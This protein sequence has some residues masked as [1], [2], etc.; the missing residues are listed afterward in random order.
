M[1]TYAGHARP[2]RY[3]HSLSPVSGRKCDAGQGAI[4]LGGCV[5]GGPR[6]APAVQEP[7]PPLGRCPGRRLLRRP[8]WLRGFRRNRDLRSE[9]GGLLRAFPGTPGGYPFA[10]HL[11]AGLPGCLPGGLAT[12]LAPVAPRRSAGGPGG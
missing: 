12:L 3:N 9:E 1:T 8:V 11:P 5:G 6:P 7:A 2:E 10:R 4:A